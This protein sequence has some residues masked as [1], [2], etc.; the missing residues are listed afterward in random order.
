M[1]GFGINR[2]NLIENGGEGIKRPIGSGSSFWT[3]GSTG[4]GDDKTYI[5][6]FHF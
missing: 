6:N 4:A 5:P 3:C 1:H 2:V